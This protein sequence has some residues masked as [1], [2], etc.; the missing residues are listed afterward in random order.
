MARVGLG[1]NLTLP[2]HPLS[3]PTNIWPVIGV[4]KSVG[5]WPTLELLLAS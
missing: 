3:W 1:F 5:E 4:R 2:T